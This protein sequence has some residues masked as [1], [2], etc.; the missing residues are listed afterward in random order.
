MDFDWMRAV[1]GAVTVC[2]LEGI[3]VAMNEMAAESY[4]KY[5]GKDLIGNSLMDCHPEPSRGKLK[6]LLQTGERNVYTIEKNGIRKLIYQAPW[7]VDTHRCGLVEISLEIPR[8]IP[9]FI[10]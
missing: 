9:H 7:F 1:P 4:S 3:I 8:D 2:N 6:R 10:R 5:G